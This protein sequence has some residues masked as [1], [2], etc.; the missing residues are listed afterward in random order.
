MALFESY[1]RRIAQIE[2][3]LAQYGIANLD[4]AKK[5]MPETLQTDPRLLSINTSYT[6]RTALTRS[7]LFINRR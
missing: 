2:K 3:V 4:E 7:P 5:L 1:D 6:K